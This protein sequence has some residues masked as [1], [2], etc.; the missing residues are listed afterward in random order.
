MM[1]GRNDEDTVY[2]CICD[3]QKPIRSYEQAEHFL[4]EHLREAHGRK[5]LFAVEVESNTRKETP[6]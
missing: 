6:Q 3:W 4:K 1:L 2:C 5:L